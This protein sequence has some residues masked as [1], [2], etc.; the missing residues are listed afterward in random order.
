MYLVSFTLDEHGN[1]PS[2]E[3]IASL[4][5]KHTHQ[6]FHEVKQEWTRVSLYIWSFQS[7]FIIKILLIQ[8]L[9]KESPRI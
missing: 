3:L 6:K 7:I 4:A 8:F 5:Q 1:G 9:H 2:I